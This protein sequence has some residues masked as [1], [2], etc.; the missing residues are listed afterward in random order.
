MIT[1]DCSAALSCNQ[2]ALYGRDL[3]KSKTVCTKFGHPRLRR[4]TSLGQA[5]FD[6]FAND[7]GCGGY[8]GNATVFDC[9]RNV[10]TA[11]LRSAIQASPD[12]FDFSSLNLAWMPRVDGVFLADTPQQLVLNG[13]VADVPFVTGEYG[14]LPVW[15]TL[16]VIVA[17]DCDD[18]GTLFSLSNSNIT[19]VS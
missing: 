16:I 13:S 2:E 3:C 6:Q 14:V 1:K 4:L 18:E 19:C 17:G 12:I 8:L 9:L 7:T 5:S 15:I 10:S 11:D